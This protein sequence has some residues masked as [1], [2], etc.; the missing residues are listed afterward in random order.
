MILTGDIAFADLRT[1]SADW[2]W[3]IPLIILTVVIHVFGLGYINEGMAGTATRAEERRYPVALFAVMMGTATLAITILHGV[4][5]YI[6]ASAFH[7]LG[8]LPDQRTA[9]LYTLGAMTSYGH[10]T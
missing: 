7:L 9:M 3:G 2:A 5:A 1:W 8:A 10:A 6:W 4:E